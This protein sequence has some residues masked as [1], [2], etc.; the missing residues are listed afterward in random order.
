MGV[1]D[2]VVLGLVLFLVTLDSTQGFT[3]LGWGLLSILITVTI[4]Y[5]VTVIVV[6]VF[7]FFMRS[8]EG[9]GVSLMKG[10]I[11]GILVFFMFPFLLK[12]SFIL[13]G[14]SRVSSMIELAMLFAFIARAFLRSYLGKLWAVSLVG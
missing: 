13:L 3:V 14:A 2:L 1:A 5:V 10:I 11:S 9:K 6:N 4:I 8:A 7:M 12:W